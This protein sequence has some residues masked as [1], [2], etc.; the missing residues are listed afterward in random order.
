MNL[1]DTSADSRHFSVGSDAVA[2]ASRKI[3][4]LGVKGEMMKTYKDS[5]VMQEHCRM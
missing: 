1:T 5:G 4:S 3:C 2:G